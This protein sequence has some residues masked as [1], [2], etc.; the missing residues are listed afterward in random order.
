AGSVRGIAVDVAH[1]TPSLLAGAERAL[2]PGGRL[3]APASALRPDSLRE[4]A[5]DDEH[6]VAAATTSAVSAPVA[7]SPRR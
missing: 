4:L 2:A 3:I 6:W 7:I 5:R 1:A